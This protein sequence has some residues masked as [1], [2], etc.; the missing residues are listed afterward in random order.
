MVE[1][2]DI[3]NRYEPYKRAEK[4]HHAL[5]SHHKFTPL[6]FVRKQAI[7]YDLVNLSI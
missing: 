5:L 6:N 3:Q 1:T 7:F 2:W 4:Q